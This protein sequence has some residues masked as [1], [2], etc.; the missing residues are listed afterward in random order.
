MRRSRTGAALACAAGIVGAAA[1]VGCGGSSGS[2]SSAT[3]ATTAATTA[4]ASATPS[5]KATTTAAGTGGT[6]APGTKLTP[7]TPALVNYKPGV[8]ANSPTYRMQVTVVSIDRGSPSELNGVELEKAQQGQTPYY[9]HLR[10]RNEG[11]GNVAAEEINPAAGFQ[12]TD[13]R[14][15][16]GQELT[17][18]GKF[19]TCET[20]EVPKQF[21]KGVTWNTCNLY[22]VG[23]GGSIVSASW[24]GG[25][26]EAYSEKPI[27]WSAG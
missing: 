10:M 26:G 5:S 18:L 19:R 11:A 7:G 2:T 8:N 25:G 14:G 6:T 12:T 4:A 1:I 21:T 27:V 17:I 13:D 15:Q 20:G 23:T 16:P 24:T 22:L 9:V 3:T